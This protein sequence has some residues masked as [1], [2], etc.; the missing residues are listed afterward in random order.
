[1]MLTYKYRIYPTQTQQRQMFQV[2]NVCRHWYN[3][4]LAERKW[5]WELDQR[6]ISK[7]QQE[8]IGVYYRKTF[9]QARIVFSQTMQT[10]CDDLDKAF[11]AFFR[12]VK[13][14]ERPGYPRFKGR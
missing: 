5:A 8:R 3:Q 4:C 10:V 11:Q 13:A 6:S 12:R 9:P 7:A 14:G 1:M 2:L